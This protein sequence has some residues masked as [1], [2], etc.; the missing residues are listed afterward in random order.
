MLFGCRHALFNVFAKLLQINVHVS[1]NRRH[2]FVKDLL[3][4]P[5]LD[6]IKFL[7]WIHIVNGI[8]FVVQVIDLL[9]AGIESFLEHYK[10][11]FEVTDLIEETFLLGQNKFIILTWKTWAICIFAKFEM[12]PIGISLFIT[13][14]LLFWRLFPGFARSLTLYN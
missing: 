1:A 6:S 5:S 4:K 7:A 2:L 9:L 11:S 8:N 14:P 12:D 3:D 13:L 10:L